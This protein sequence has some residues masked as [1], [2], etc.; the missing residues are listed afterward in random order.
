MDDRVAR[1]VAHLKATE[2]AVARAQGELNASSVTARSGDRSVRVVVGA[3]GEVTNLEFLDG[4]YR[5]M[6]AAQLSTSVLEAMNAARAEMARRVV[7]TLDPLTR[8]TSRGMA[9]E[10]TGVDWGS[11]FGSLIE[12]TSVDRQPTAMSRLRDE[13]HEDDE[14]TAAPA[15]RGGEDP[16]RGCE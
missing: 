6:A 8:L 13:I 7:H 14:E 12:E 15:G 11:I 2:E 16:R 5:T 3:K 1:A 9:P 4:K 10:R